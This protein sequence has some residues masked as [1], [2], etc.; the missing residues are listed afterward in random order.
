[1]EAPADLVHVGFPEDVKKG[2]FGRG[3][4]PVTGIGDSLGALPILA[5]GPSPVPSPVP[6]RQV[7]MVKK[8]ESEI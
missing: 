7:S 1:M 4:G 2:A 5:P 3:G 8:T 6:E